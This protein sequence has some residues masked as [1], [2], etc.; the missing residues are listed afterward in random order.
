MNK[1]YK[2]NINK[3]IVFGNRHEAI[4]VVGPDGSEPNL[5]CIKWNLSN[6]KEV[7]GI[8]ISFMNKFNEE[9]C[10][11]FVKRNNDEIRRTII[12][13][14]IFFNSPTNKKVHYIY[15]SQTENT[16]SRISLDSVSKNTFF[17]IVEKSKKRKSLPKFT[18]S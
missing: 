1:F 13:Y 18:Y 15:W 14:F 17:D 6:Y 3:R 4:E 9:K 10:V 8:E 11:T 16:R 2:S 7:K 5:E 12:E